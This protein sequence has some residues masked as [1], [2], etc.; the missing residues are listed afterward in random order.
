MFE[1]FSKSARFAVIDAQKEARDLKSER[2]DVEHVLLGVLTTADKPL[3]DLL[4]AAGLTPDA[5]RTSIGQHKHGEPL[6]EED[7]EALK[8]IGIDLEA[9]RES[10]GATFGDDALD[11]VEPEERRGLFGKRMGG[12]IPFRNS[13]KKTLE[14][15]LREAL[16]RGDDYIGSEH[17][18]L[19][20][21]RAPNA[22]ARDAIE[23]HVTSAELRRQLEALLDRAA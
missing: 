11:R 15:A 13:A 1:R 19:G 4:T 7:A 22:I 18:L 12:H 20:I 8:S 14:L 17:M 23:E 10:L 21:L 16:R 3:A 5:V 9:V 2:I 6:G